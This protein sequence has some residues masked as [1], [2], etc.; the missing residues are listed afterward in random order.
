MQ[1]NESN[2]DCPREFVSAVVV[3]ECS[4]HGT[5]SNKYCWCS[6]GY[7][8]LGD[9]VTAENFD[10]NV[11]IAFLKH[12][13]LLSAIA[14]IAYLLFYVFLLLSVYRDLGY[15]FSKLRRKHDSNVH[16]RIALKFAVVVAPLKIVEGVYRF[17]T[18]EVLGDD[19]LVTVVHSIAGAYLWS[20]IHPL[21]VI[22]WASVVIKMGATFEGGKG[23]E[24]QAKLENYK[25]LVKYFQVFITIVYMLPLV[26][27]GIQKS[28]GAYSLAK[29]EIQMYLASA[30]L[31]CHGIAFLFLHTFGAIPILMS[32]KDQI[33]KSSISTRGLEEKRQKVAKFIMLSK[34][35][36]RGVIVV[37]LASCFPSFTKMCSYFISI[38]WV[39]SPINCCAVLWMILYNGGDRH[40]NSNAIEMSTLSPSPK[41]GNMI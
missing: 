29:F 30:W 17:A 31:V 19:A 32:L 6:P 12:T 33:E 37:L 36:N 9:L 24:T 1:Y 10:C 38:A 2:H 18:S 28:D 8:G 20:R 3:G 26:S 34:I 15:S 35:F 25:Q 40:K 21:I 7:T 27:L 5:C 4:G 22:E 16:L 41:G 13:W 14:Y 39:L 11:N 23:K